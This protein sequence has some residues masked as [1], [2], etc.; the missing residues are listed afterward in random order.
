MLEMGSGGQGSANG[1][2]TGT[3]QNSSRDP[4]VRGRDG[5]TQNVA[6]T[7]RDDFKIC[8]DGTARDGTGRLQ[9]SSGRDR[10]GTN[11]V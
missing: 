7:G 9:I 5:T 4:H 2:T 11:P 1:T 10:D 3:G 6:G 8:R